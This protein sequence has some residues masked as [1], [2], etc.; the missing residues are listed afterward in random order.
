M[1]RDS[2]WA[3]SALCHA[4]TRVTLCHLGFDELTLAEIGERVDLDRDRF[5]V[6][7]VDGVCLAEAAAIGCVERVRTLDAIHL[8][9]AL[10]L[11]EA[12]SFLTFDGRQR[13]AAASLGLALAPT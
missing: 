11:P 1:E 4:E 8:A 3:A 6:V 5:Y 7:P 13:A 10:R 2:D 9:A 12:P